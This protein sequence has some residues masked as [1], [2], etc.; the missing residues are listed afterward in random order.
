MPSWSDC[1][2]DNDDQQGE[3]G[4]DEQK[5]NQG[6][7]SDCQRHGRDFPRGIDGLIR[8]EGPGGNRCGCPIRWRFGERAPRCEI[9]ERPCPHASVSLHLPG[10]FENWL[11][12]HGPRMEFSRLDASGFLKEIESFRTSELRDFDVSRANFTHSAQSGSNFALVCG[13]PDDS[14]N[15]R[16]EIRHLQ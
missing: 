2:K 13:G 8:V 16:Y 9:R 10:F 4:Y 5:F 7:S 14:I 1:G 12:R 6:E 15:P 3:G 11:H